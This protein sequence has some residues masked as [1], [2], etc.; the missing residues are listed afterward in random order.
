MLH[1]DTALLLKSIFDP[2]FEVPISGWFEF[3]ELTEVVEFK[4][5]EVIKLQ[6]SQERYFNILLHGSAGLFLWKKTNFVCLDFAF[7]HQVCCDYMSILT[8]KETALQVI[9]LE[10]SRLLRI[11]SKHFFELCQRPTGQR[12]LQI[13][14]EQSFI[15]KQQQQI[16]LLTLSAE[17]R[18]VILSERF[19]MIHQRVAQKHIAS[20]LGITPQ[21]L[22]RIRA[23]VR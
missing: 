15:D 14:T 2:F 23:N 19:P 12:I 7:D 5:D 20:Y 11:S 16:E 4:K 1:N 9:L 13:A 10:D 22:S 17:E 21:S 18:Y 8:Q 3:A 6:H